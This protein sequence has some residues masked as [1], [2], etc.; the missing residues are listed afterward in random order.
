MVETQSLRTE[1]FSEI[2]RIIRRDADAIV[3]LWA[4]E[5]RRQ[6][7]E[8]QSK[9]WDVLKNALP[10][11]L[12]AVADSLAERTDEDEEQHVGFAEE[13]GE[14]RWATGW[15]L[16]DLVSD[17]QLLRQTVL[18]YV[19][20]ERGCP[21][22]FKERSAINLYIDDAISAAVKRYVE[23]ESAELERSRNRLNEFLAILGHELRNPLNGIAMGLQLIALEQPAERKNTEAMMGQQVALMTRL[24]D[25]MLDLS[26]IARGQLSLV[27]C[28]T[29]LNKLIEH[30][31][32]SV[33]AS[34]Q[35]VNHQF[36]IKLHAEEI[37]IDGDGARLQQVF[38]NLLTNAVKYTE[39]GGT[40]ALAV[41]SKPEG[42]VV[43]IR[44]N[45]Q[46]IDALILPH[47]FDLFVQ[48]P[49][50]VG[51]GLG[52]GLALAKAIIEL[53]GGSISA[54]SSGVGLGSEF[55]ITLPAAK[56]GTL[57]QN[58]PAAPETP[59]TRAGEHCCRILVV[60]DV[61]PAARALAAL[62][63]QRGHT[64]FTAGDG[65]KAVSVALAERPEVVLIDIGLPKLNGYEVATLLRA[66]PEFQ[67]ALFIAMTGYTDTPHRDQSQQVGIDHHFVK[68]VD[69]AA[70]DA[71][72]AEHRTRGGRPGQSS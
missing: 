37:W 13:H 62:L 50:N 35:H 57:T 30:A 38:V 14:Q 44:D 52:I 41:D 25:D 55:I 53:H 26:R 71:L 2:A 20:R 66:T 45:G 11:F 48:S 9:H 1:P 22:T 70:I 40:I 16:S 60:D 69:V 72:I 58:A 64:T 15:D 46:G 47:I 63:R 12:K 54:E 7:P 29:E 5:S 51:R 4:V 65:E 59:A 3:N 28:A 67:N 61:E 49:E 6:R 19:E 33:R 43:R 21:P 18:D 23:N 39:A 17:Y 36:Q 10:K 42:I 56:R 31:V 68:P 24:V 8:T 32:Q 27:K 34:T